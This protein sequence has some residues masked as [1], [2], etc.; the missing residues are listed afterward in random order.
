MMKL[1]LVGFGTVG[2]G[3]AQILHER[4]DALRAQYGFEAQIVGVST[5]RRG[6]LY[7]PDGLDLGALLDLDAGAPLDDYPFEAQRGWDVPQLIAEGG[8]DVLVE[9]SYTDL[10]TA[11]PALDYCRAALRAGLDLVLAN[12]GPVA[13]ALPELEALARQ[14]GRRLRFEATV[15]AGTP[16]LA[17]GREGL[18]GSG[19]RA[20]R[21]ILNGSTNLML[22]RM[23]EGLTY[24]EA[25]AEASALGYLEADPSADVEGW[26]AAGKA[27]ILARALFGAPLTLADI[28]VKGITGLT[29]ADI[30]A[31][32]AAGERWKLIAEVTAEGGTVA[33]RRLSL[34][35][36]LAS[37]DGATNAITYS[38]DLLGNVTLVGPGAGRQQT[39]AGLLADLLH[40]H[41]HAV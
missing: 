4:A 41:R 16:A 36:P 38:S 40:L 8:A 14:T 17:L 19:I 28:N 25:E 26:D 31:A 33:P 10:K 9:V 5:L 23:G 32:R 2:Q 6:S 29:V 21:G 22:T 30:A 24:A 12:K 39:A 35:D 3:L 20:A 1:L 18:A 11:Q 34:A 13:L 15:M 27:I 7:A 37:V